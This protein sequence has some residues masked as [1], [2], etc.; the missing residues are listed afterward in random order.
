MF[1]RAQVVVAAAALVA[2]S[3][4]DGALTQLFLATSPR[5]ET[6]DIRGGYYVPIAYGPDVR[7]SRYARSEEEADK[8]MDWTLRVLTSRGFT[9]PASVATP[10]S[11][12]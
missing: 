1:V 9:V 6:E 11:R 10:P 7:M 5:V 4:A 12:L 3:P 2:Y 8:V